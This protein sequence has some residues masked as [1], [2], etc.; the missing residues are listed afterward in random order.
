MRASTSF[1]APAPSRKPEL[2]EKPMK[3]KYVLFTQTEDG[4][5]FARVDRDGMKTTDR[6]GSATEF[7]SASAAYEVGELVLKCREKSRWK[8]G[9][10]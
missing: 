3:K 5:V 6:R 2:G 9:Q 10:R 8:V 1:G 7:D 4:L